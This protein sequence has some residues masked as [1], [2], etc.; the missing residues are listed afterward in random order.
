M[1]KMKVWNNGWYSKDLIESVSYADQIFI[2]KLPK[3]FEDRTYGSGVKEI[4]YIEVCENQIFGT[5]SVGKSLFYNQRKNKIEI[6]LELDF[7][8][9]IKMTNVQF[10]RYLANKYMER[11][12]DISELL[13]QDFDLKIYLTDL[14][15]FFITNS[16]L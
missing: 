15:D 14:E 3:Y 1:E 7:L 10:C 16:V 9:A 13:I 5:N 12:L 11:S 4:F 8:I 2:G 6:G